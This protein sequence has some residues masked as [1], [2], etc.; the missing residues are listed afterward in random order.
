MLDVRL[1]A[2]R[3]TTL[4]ADRLIRSRTRFV[5]MSGNSFL[6][7]SPGTR[8]PSDKFLIIQQRSQRG[9]GLFSLLSSV[10]CFIDIAERNSLTPL[11]DFENFQTIYNDEHISSTRNSWEY[12]FDQLNNYSLDQVYGSKNVYVT[13][14]RYPLGYDYSITTIPSLFSIFE[15]YIKIKSNIVEPDPLGIGHSKVLGV[16]F[17]GQEMRTARGHWLPPSFEQIRRAIDC[18]LERDRYEKIFLVT[19]DSNLLEQV[20]SA[21]GNLVIHSASFRTNGTNAYKSASRPRHFYEL[22]REVLSDA[23]WLSKCGGLIHCSSNVAEFSRFLN[24][25]KYRST[26]FINNGPNSRFYP[27]YKYMWGVKAVLPE[28][29]GGFSTDDRTLQYSRGC[30]D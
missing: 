28:S 26:I 19:E 24:R 4:A 12:Y 25:G 3:G 14:N 30:L 21:Y 15:R 17:R 8:H 1:K 9:R 20:Q 23:L 22:G 10:L 6:H 29:F 7:C 11:V 18:M 27:F 5:Q 13:S 2:Y 16:H